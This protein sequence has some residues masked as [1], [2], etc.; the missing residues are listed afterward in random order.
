M[1]YVPR[2]TESLLVVNK[3]PVEL[4]LGDLQLK[5]GSREI[6]G[7]VWAATTLEK[8]DCLLVLSDSKEAGKVGDLHCN[9]AHSPFRW[10]GDDPFWPSKLDVYYL[11]ERIGSCNNLKDKPDG[12]TLSFPAQTSP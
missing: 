4:H 6:R 11:G 3:G 8:E 7:Q 9:Q 12:C 10:S 5:S 1:F 2:R